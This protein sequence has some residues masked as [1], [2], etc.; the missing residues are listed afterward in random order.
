MSTTLHIYFWIRNSGKYLSKTYALSSHAIIGHKHRRR[1][2]T[3]EKV[4]AAVRGKD[5]R[6]ITIKIVVNS[7]VTVHNIFY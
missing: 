1:I 4:V 6:D 2:Q 3:A 5:H 7:P